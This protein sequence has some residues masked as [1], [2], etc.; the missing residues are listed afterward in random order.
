MSTARRD[1]SRSDAPLSRVYVEQATTL[2]VNFTPGPLEFDHQ[3]AA[4]ILAC[5]DRCQCVIMTEKSADQQPR[6]VDTKRNFARRMD[7]DQERS[8][9]QDA[10][11]QL[12]DASCF[13]GDV[14]T[15]P[16]ARPPNVDQSQDTDCGMRKQTSPDRAPSK[17]Q[18]ISLNL[19]WLLVSILSEFYFRLR[20]P[21]KLWCC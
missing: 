16:S 14:E 12:D 6:R 20:G 8:V 15:F 13:R 11:P 19:I 18:S 5:A 4:A 17:S 9:V 21:T 7:T 3:E 10:L 2:S 1:Q